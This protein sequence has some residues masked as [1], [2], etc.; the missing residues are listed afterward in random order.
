[1]AQEGVIRNFMVALGFKTDNTGLGQMQ[2]A[3][4]GIDWQA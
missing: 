4:E 2:S 3:M 1:M